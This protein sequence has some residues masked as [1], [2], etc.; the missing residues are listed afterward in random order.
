MVFDRLKNFLF[1]AGIG[2]KE[3]STISS[4]IWRGNIKTLRITSGLAVSIGIVYLIPNLFT[5]SRPGYWIPYAFLIVGSLMII[6][7]LFLIRRRRRERN[8]VSIVVCYTQILLIFLYSCTLSA[9][10]ANFDLPAT[11][12]IVFISIL[13]L[14]IDDRPIRMI[15]FI[16]LES[17]IYLFVSH[18]FK[19]PRAFIIDVE[20]IAAFSVVGMVLYGVMCT[21]NIRELYQGSRI[22][23]IQKSIIT[24]LATV[25]E[26]RDEETGG[27]IMRCEAYVEKLLER[28]REQSRYSYLTDDYC[29]NVV[30]AAAMHDIGKIKIPDHI[31]N[32]PGRLTKE[33]FEVMKKHSEFGAEI[34]Q[35]TMYDIEE[36]EYCKI[37]FNIAR[38]HHE[39]YDGK[40]YPTGLKGEDIPL[41]A[42][43]M[44]L[45]DVYDALISPRVYKEP[46]SEE[47]AKE[48]ILEGS[49]TQF[50]PAL[51][52]LFLECV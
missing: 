49:G 41:E 10:S 30:L 2:R 43:I 51:V 8:V 20:N 32:K 52:P 22:E 16:L 24:S 9:H 37:A 28:M 48:I 23:K 45:A 5:Q 50:D 19:S 7:L 13:P 26:E 34:I 11:S 47:K 29:S 15:L 21:R 42:R 17:V 12:A 14:S 25:L 39:R 3:Y 1:Y 35:R 4:M 38:Y 18:F 40:G 44:A 31:L 6:G 27:H 33:E 46:Y 36:E